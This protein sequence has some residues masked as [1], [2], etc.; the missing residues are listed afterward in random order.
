MFVLAITF[1]MFSVPFGALQNAALG[2]MTVAK[3]ILPAVFLALLAIRLEK[4]KLH[5]YFWL[6]AAFVVATTPSFLLSEKYFDIVPNLVS[7]IILFVLLHNAL[8]R[9]GD[10]RTLFVGYFLGLM[11]VSLLAMTAFVFGLDA[12]DAVGRPLVEIWYGLPVMLGTEDNPNAFATL[13]VVGAPIA[14]FLRQTTASR[15]MRRVYGSGALLFIVVIALTFSRSGIAGAMV[16]CALAI[17]FGKSRSARSRQVLVAA[18]VMLAILGAV[19]AASI[20]GLGMTG[21]AGGESGGVSVL[22]NKELSQG[23]RLQLAEQYIPLIAENPL[24]GIGFG[25]LP[26]LMEQRTGLYNN[27]HNILFGVAIEF[28]LI[29]ALLF[30][31]LI[32]LSLRSTARGMALAVSRPDRTTGACILAVIAG[33]FIHGM[34]H[35]IYVNLML[36]LFIGLGG[37]YAT[38]VRNSRLIRKEPS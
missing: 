8:S 36:W 18:L 30:T 3:L 26:A 20:V 22:S 29:A 1:V 21:D 14:L 19:L 31:S 28:G 35:E 33:L 27:S 15:W 16:G 6:I 17:Y 32:L 5:P 38:L 10:L 25:N 2:G 37:V 34:F 7:Y 11:V 23:Y 13:L 24:V 9:V 12:G 4:L